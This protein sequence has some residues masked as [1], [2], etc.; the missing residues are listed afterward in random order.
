MSRQTGHCVETAGQALAQPRADGDLRA[1]HEI[2][3][4]VSWRRIR[5][6]VSSLLVL[7]AAT[8]NADSVMALDQDYWQWRAL[9]QPFSKDDIPRV[10]RPAK[11]VVDWT[12]ATVARRIADVEAFEHRWRALV[13][14]ASDAV[15]EQVDYRLLGSAI[16]RAHWELSVEQGWRRNPDFYIDQSLGSVYELLLQPPPFETSRQAEIVARIRQIP[17]TLKAAK[18]NLDDMR[19]PFVQVAIDLLDDIRGKSERVQASLA[20]QF[21]ASYRRALI[22][23]LPR[24]IDA[25]EH[26]R[27]W[28]QDRLAKSRRDTAIGR[29]NYEFFLRKVA[30][31]AYT[32][33]QLLAMSRQEWAR[34]MAFESYAQ[35][36]L[37]SADTPK[38]FADSEAEI[39]AE[40]AA[41][42]R[43]RRFLGEAGIL[44]VPSDL[45]HYRN[46]PIP[47]Y[48]EAWQ[49]LGVADDFTG[50]SRLD[51][52]SI[53]YI[54]APSPD[55]GFFNLS[56]AQDPRPI[57]VHEGIP[58]HW[59]QLSLGWRN[60]NP[61]RRR[62]YDSS[63]NEGIGFHAEEMMLQ[64]GLFDDN[65]QTRATLYRY[66]R[67]RA[68]RVE[69]DVK[70][71]VGEFSLAQAADYLERTVPM[72]HASA[73]SEAALFA[74]TPGQAI[75]YQIGKIQITELLADARRAQG[76]AFSLLRFND[77]VWN[78][79]NVPLSLQRWELL[80]DASAVP[81]LE[82]VKSSP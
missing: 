75:S 58:G 62:Y 35:A 15:R 79:G 37:S 41:E 70:L 32:P 43:I 47:A 18:D 77:F 74:S 25:L 24:A 61:I 49:D 81:P 45:P 27:A 65:A 22:K 78:N 23:A 71:A 29:D 56:R 39:A 8:A 12:P 59:F 80:D 11:F 64:A 28:L 51:Q 14:A 55:L 72:D 67:L 5:W 6:L 46:L 69:V 63:A 9:E 60:S 13:P 21:D 54:P 20:P 68:L 44:T 52:D 4:P 73:L 48:I 57:I 30:L 53:S 1:S 38:L 31:L 19:Q 10:E 33:E 36:R 26:Y 2:V 17:R 16:A 7:A 50:P 82:T 40:R 42:A 76:K 34:S 3:G 66:M